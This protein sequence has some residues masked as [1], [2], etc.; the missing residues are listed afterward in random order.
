MD[1]TRLEV[2][3]VLYGFCGGWFGRDSY[4]DKRV[5]ARGRD[6]VVCRTEGGGVECATGN[7]DE[8][9]EYTTKPIEW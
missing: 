7:V 5:E 4:D 6:W 2:G 3:D 8:L 1:F 9:V